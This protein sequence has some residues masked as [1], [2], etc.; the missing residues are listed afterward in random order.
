MADYF[1]IRGAGWADLD[2]RDGSFGGAYVHSPFI[3]S[4]L[5]LHL[6]AFCSFPFIAPAFPL[7]FSLVSPSFLPHFSFILR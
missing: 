3:Y 6:S 1:A 5:L 7:H 4:S 2:R